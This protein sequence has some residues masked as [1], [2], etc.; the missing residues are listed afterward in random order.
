[1]VFLRKR[2]CSFWKD[3]LDFVI[4]ENIGVLRTARLLIGMARTQPYEIFVT[5]SDEGYIRVKTIPIYNFTYSL[6]FNDICL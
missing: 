4:D 1:M 2:N 5:A 3:F 6:I